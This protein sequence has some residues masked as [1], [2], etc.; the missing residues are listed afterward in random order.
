MP[1][2][3]PADDS[4]K[5]KW[6]PLL[7]RTLSV[8]DALFYGP[9]PP[10]VTISV[11]G[12]ALT[13]PQC[14]GA[15]ESSAK[16]KRADDV[17]EDAGDEG[18]G[19]SS[20]SDS[21]AWH[22]L[23]LAHFPSPRLQ[24]AHHAPCAGTRRRKKEE[25]KRKKKDTKDRKKKD[26]KER[27]KE[28]RKKEKHRKVRSVA[29]SRDARSASAFINPHRGFSQEKRSARLPNAGQGKRRICRARTRMMTLTTPTTQTCAESAISGR[30][31]R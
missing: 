25:K 18:G 22:P 15:S 19:S 4:S 29:P 27:K 11:C 8:G 5:R 2:S 16:R 6:S 24:W 20:D 1:H 30:K 10:R 26:K 9:R 3:R 13:T 23:L 7:S 28:K 17:P 31:I 21:E 12:R 14:R